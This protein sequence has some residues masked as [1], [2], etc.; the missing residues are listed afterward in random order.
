MKICIDARS[1]GFAGVLNYVSCLLRSLLEID[2]QNEYIILSTVKDKKWNINNVK[3]IVIPYSNPLGWWFWSNINLPH[4]LENEKVDVYH[5]LKHVTAF[6]G[7]FKKIITFHS[8]RFFFLPEHYKWYDAL[9]WRI[10]YPTAAKKY[11]LIIV[12]SEAEKENYTKYIGVPE[13][14][15][16]VINLAADKRFQ[17]IDDVNKLQEAKTKYN[18]PEHFL[19]FVGR[20]LPVKNIETIIKAYHLVKKRQR[21]EQKL[22]IV[23][24]KTWFFPKI[25]SLIEKLNLIED[26]LFTGP[27]Y[28]ELP[29]I[30]NLAD[31]FL[32][33]S[34]YEAFPAV[35]LEAMAC[36]TPVITSNS[37]GLLEVIGNAGLTVSPTSVQDF[38]D[39]IVKILS[40]EQLRKSMIERGFK[41]TKI[42]SWETCA[43][44]T[45]AV[46]REI[47]RI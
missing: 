41:R 45:L 30:Y 2:N 20:I 47:A 19:L 31:L 1:P 25:F 13:S 21:I 42:F 26:V 17:I 10:M 7:N 35:P 12:V 39:A 44:E 33:P 22:V 32:F 37:G 6:R 46:Y 36:G 5:S 23:G 40:S 16:R 24:H 8:A 34:F 28:E 4:I 43:K 15:F 11:D 18:L 14:R 38:A 9:H 27:V 3:E 29:C